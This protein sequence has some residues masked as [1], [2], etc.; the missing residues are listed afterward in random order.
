MTA[1][2]QIALT[3]AIEVAGGQTALADKLGVGQGHVWNWLNRDKEL[4]PKIAVKI[5]AVTGVSRKKLCPTF[6]WE[7]M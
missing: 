7:Q 6:P 1:P 3:A 2:H 5:E 4:D